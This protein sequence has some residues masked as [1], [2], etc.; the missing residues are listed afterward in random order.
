[1]GM[2]SSDEPYPIKT[3]SEIRVNNYVTLLYGFTPNEDYIWG[4][5]QLDNGTITEPYI[6]KIKT[7][8][9]TRYVDLGFYGKWD[10][11]HIG[12]RVEV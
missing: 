5:L 4:C 8:D 3:H 2:F 12:I 10:I 9:K 11:D 1:M 7:L 6:M